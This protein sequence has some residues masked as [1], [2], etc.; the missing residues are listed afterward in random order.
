M[1]LKTIAIIAA[2]FIEVSDII[3]RFKIKDE[4][5]RLS[6]LLSSYVRLEV[7]ITGYG[8]CS[9][10]A[11]LSK[12]L[13]NTCKCDL[14]LNLGFAGVL[15]PEDLPLLLPQE[16]HRVSKFIPNGHDTTA[17]EIILK[18][19]PEISCQGEPGTGVKLTSS[20]FPISNSSYIKD[21]SV[22]V[23][24]E[25]YG[26]AYLANVLE[27]PYKLIKIGSDYV[28]FPA[29]DQYLRNEPEIP[30]KLIGDWLEQYLCESIF[31][32]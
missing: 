15:S 31:P 5:Q 12:Y 9:S 7:C 2:D 11:T 16:I 3:K 32:R 27:I 19:F 8:C 25:G 26:I 21:D 1:V 23:D 30:A 10:M 29:D 24:M 4:N 22:M 6:N 13:L 17:A 18:A 14:L 20:D 28:D